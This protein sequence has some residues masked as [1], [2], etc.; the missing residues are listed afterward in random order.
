MTGGFKI[1]ELS[2]II[3]GIAGRQLDLLGDLSAKLSD[4]TLDVAPVDITQDRSGPAT[5]LPFN[6]IDLVLG[7]DAGHLIERDHATIGQPDGKVGKIIG[8]GSHVIR[9]PENDIG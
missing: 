9:V 3:D 5:S 4:E 6:R 2:G 7:L 1:L 8:L